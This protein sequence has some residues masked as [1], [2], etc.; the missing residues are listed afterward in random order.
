MALVVSAREPVILQLVRGVLPMARVTWIVHVMLV[1][2]GMV[3][4]AR[5]TL[6]L[7]PNLAARPLLIA[8]R[9]ILFIGTGMV[10]AMVTRFFLAMRAAS[11]M[12][13]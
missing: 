11:L 4:V 3:I 7:L 2:L 10:M 8:A 6:V 1:T 12:V 9:R 13:T 5:L